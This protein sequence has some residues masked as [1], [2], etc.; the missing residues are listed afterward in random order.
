MTPKPLGICVCPVVAGLQT[1]GWI[2]VGD[3]TK[4]SCHVTEVVG[5]PV[6]VAWNCSVPLKGTSGLIGLT[7]TPTGV[8]F[9]PQA[10][11][12]AH[13]A[14]NSIAAL[15]LNI[16]L[17]ISFTLLSEFA[18]RSGHLHHVLSDRACSSLMQ[19]PRMSYPP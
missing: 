17:P 7:V 1:V 2:L 14:T 4:H 8:E 5:V 3:G 6:T 18:A 9:P 16:L 15:N 12:N 11:R 13:A 10:D 19:I